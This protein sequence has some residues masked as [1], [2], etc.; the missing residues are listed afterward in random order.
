M[1]IDGR[2]K[3]VDPKADCLQSESI[4]HGADVIDVS[5]GGGLV[6]RL[7]VVRH[8]RD[9]GYYIMKIVE[10]RKDPKKEGPEWDPVSQQNIPF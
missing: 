2:P 5:L 6:M 10:V 1:R 9:P 7:K 4:P 3:A 8:Y